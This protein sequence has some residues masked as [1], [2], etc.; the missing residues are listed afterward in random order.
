MRLNRYTEVSFCRGRDGAWRL[1]LSDYAD[2]A[3]CR[4]I[5]TIDR[6]DPVKHCNEEQLW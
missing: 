1:F 4:L 5:H 3:I 2:R 6:I